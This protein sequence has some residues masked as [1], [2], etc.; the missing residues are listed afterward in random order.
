[1]NADGTSD[2]KTEDAMTRITLFAP[3]I[4]LVGFG[5]PKQER[6]IANNLHQFPSVKIV[7]G[8]GGTFDVWAGRIFRAPKWL[9]A[10][11][12]EWLWRLMQEPK[13]FRRIWNAVIVFPYAWLVSYFHS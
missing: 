11:G 2:E 5:H 12:L 9:R 13:R 8:V 1:V 4:L 6:W 10:L 3:E 7:V